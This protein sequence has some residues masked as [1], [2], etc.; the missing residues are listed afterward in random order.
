MVVI[1][2]SGP[3]GSG[4]TTQAKKIAEY[5][6]LRYYSAGM[7][8]RKMAEERGI[9][10]EELSRIATKDPSID[11][12]IDRRTYLEALKGDIVIDGHLTAWIIADIADVR[13]LITA[14][15]ATRIKRI[16][17]RDGKS[18]MEAY[19]ETV[20]REYLQKIRFRKYY[21]I[22][23]D[24]LSIF[25]MIVNTESLGIDDTFEIVKTAIEKILKRKRKD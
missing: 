8:F 21:G 14:P 10:I 2:V 16:A 9:S 4:K 22:D 15:L 5:F 13:I 17:L 6:G 24:D 18:L 3:P 12:E 23:T 7:I 1:V 25:D 20:M 19:H 11:I